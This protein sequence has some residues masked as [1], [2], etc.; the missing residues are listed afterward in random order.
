[1]LTKKKLLGFIPLLILGLMFLGGC[2]KP[3]PEKMADHVVDKLITE[4]SL[5]PAQQVQLNA[6]KTELLAKVAEM[7]KSHE[8][9]HDEFIAELQKDV[10][11]Q[12][13]LKKMVASRR[14]EMDELVNLAI[15]RLAKF[16]DSLSPDQ[17]VKLVELLKKMEKHRKSC[18]ME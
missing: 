3:S 13:Q 7:K 9:M 11:D 18:F 10:L 4:L 6:T 17:R 15:D 1:M 5:T 16:H 14:G 8:G 2:H 12:G